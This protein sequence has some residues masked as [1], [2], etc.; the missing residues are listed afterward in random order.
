[1]FS[2][3]YSLSRFLPHQA[4]QSS[5]PPLLLSIRIITNFYRLFIRFTCLNMTNCRPRLSRSFIFA[6]PSN[7]SLLHF[8]RFSFVGYGA[9][10][11][12]HVEFGI[13]RRMGLCP[14]DR[15]YSHGKPKRFCVFLI[16]GGESPGK[17]IGDFLW[18]LFVVKPGRGEATN[19]S[20]ESWFNRFHSN[21][22]KV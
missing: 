6:L 8:V 18:G 7:F 19:P 3:P 16:L 4:S 1:M 14:Q 9:F 13:V 15:P 5:H 2:P 20:L 21:I 10:V 12:F 17:S 22:S 11:G